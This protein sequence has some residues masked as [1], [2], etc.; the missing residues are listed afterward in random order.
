MMHCI[1]MRS[2]CMDPNH[3]A[4]VSWSQ[5]PSP[6]PR[7]DDFSIHFFHLFVNTKEKSRKQNE[8]LLARR[9]GRKPSRWPTLSPAKVTSRASA[10]LWVFLFVPILPICIV[11]QRWVLCHLKISPPTV[12]GRTCWA[13]FITL[14]M[15]IKIHWFISTILIGKMQWK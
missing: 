8:I 10:P 4:P 7:D 6:H 15:F 2:E 5:L 11:L 1:V 14:T 12:R 13:T 9:Y 3:H